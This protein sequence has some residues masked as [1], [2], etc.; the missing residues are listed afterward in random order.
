[1]ILLKFVDDLKHM[2]DYNQHSLILFFQNIALLSISLT[3]T[4]I[5]SFLPIDRNPLTKEYENPL[6]WFTEFI[7]IPNFLTK[8]KK[9]YIFNQ[10]LSLIS[11]QYLFLRLRSFVMQFKLA[12]ANRY[13]YTR[14]N[15]VDVNASYASQIYSTLSGWFKTAFNFSEHEC[16]LPESLIKERRLA[17]KNMNSKLRELSRI[18]S[19]YFINAID[20]DNC[21]A[22]WPIQI[23]LKD[24]QRCRPFCLTKKTSG[25]SHRRDDF[26]RILE[27]KMERNNHF[28]AE[29]VHRMDLPDLGL[30]LRIYLL[31]TFGV[32]SVMTMGLVAY[33]NIGLSD[34]NCRD[35]VSCFAHILQSPK[36]IV[37]T[38]SGALI[39]LN[40]GL[41]AYDNGFL[42]YYSVLCS[43][44]TQK[45]IKMIGRENEFHSY[46]IV[47]F[48]LSEEK[49]RKNLW[50][51]ASTLELLSRFNLSCCSRENPYNQSSSLR[52][53]AK[54]PNDLLFP[55][56][57]AQ[58][59]EIERYSSGNLFESK[60]SEYRV[61][62]IDYN[63]LEDFNANMDYLVDLVQILQ[64][65]FDDLKSR[66][67]IQLNLN[68]F[69]GSLATAAVFALLTSK[70]NASELMLTS[71]LG[72]L[73]FVP[74]IYSLFMAATT[75]R[76]V[77]NLPSSVCHI[78]C[79]ENY[80]AN[81]KTAP[82]SSEISTGVWCR[83]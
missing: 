50:K 51:N 8:S 33:I 36:M 11:A 16:H 44:R 83:L 48:W 81:C 4:T 29:P 24:G 31:A 47:R 54:Q 5:F 3:F 71:A 66:L 70:I 1:M 60:V 35:L 32:L 74:M 67:T 7:Q 53:L 18:Y 62:Q 30:V 61:N 77:S 79:A 38:I 41:N 56:H 73:S 42:A 76:C 10:L 80:L 68:I 58:Q 63:E 23:G 49:F 25:L 27:L 40:I 9:T 21:F 14:I 57:E 19:L 55:H 26:E 72:V 65:E 13:R 6:L 82:S 20:F 69:F 28:I 64:N 78:S 59:V 52:A 46:H 34:Q 17:L 45:V 15:I 37:G 39:V 2:Q 43:S 12:K 22:D 75:E